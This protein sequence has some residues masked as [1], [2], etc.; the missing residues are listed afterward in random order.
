MKIDLAVIGGP[1]VEYSVFPYHESTRKTLTFQ[2]S[3]ESVDNKYET[4]TV[5]GETEETLGRHRLVA[6]LDVKKPWGD[7]FGQVAATQYFHDASVHRVDTYLGASAFEAFLKEE[8]ARVSG[9]LGQLG[10][11][12]A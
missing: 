8:I 5:A 3:V 1:V 9:V 6:A 12:R 7:M 10:L 11:V 4:I 2:Y